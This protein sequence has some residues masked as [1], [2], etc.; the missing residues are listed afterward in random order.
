MEIEAGRFL[1]GWQNLGCPNPQGLSSFSHIF[2]IKITI[3]GSHILVPVFTA[4]FSKIALVKGSRRLFTASSLNSAWGNWISRVTELQHIHSPW[5][6]HPKSTEA[7][8]LG[9]FAGCTLCCLNASVTMPLSNLSGRMM[10]NPLAL[11]SW[12]WSDR[13]ESIHKGPKQWHRSVSPPYMDFVWEVLYYTS[14]KHPSKRPVNCKAKSLD[15]S[16]WFSPKKNQT[17]TNYRIQETKSVW[18]ATTVRGPQ[19]SSVGT[20]IAWRRSFNKCF[21]SWMT[22][23]ALVTCQD[24]VHNS[25]A[26]VMIWVTKSVDFSWESLHYKVTLVADDTRASISAWRFWRQTVS[27][28]CFQVLLLL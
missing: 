21:C 17:L 8:R 3:L 5:L 27:S 9:H 26:S 13:N 28:W 14:C 6:N 24:S 20:S 23:E 4:S 11:E 19:S 2:P 22:L 15:R 7:E 12:Y 16:V 25:S 18:G 1:K 10:R